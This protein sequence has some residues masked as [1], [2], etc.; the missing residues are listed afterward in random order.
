MRSKSQMMTLLL[1]TEIPSTFL[2]HYSPCMDSILKITSWPIMAAV[3]YTSLSLVEG[4][5]E[6][7][8]GK[9]IFCVA[10]SSLKS[11]PRNPTQ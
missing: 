10:E 4:G 2:L 9:R 6:Y 7:D 5:E 8:K 1:G 3:S 11:F